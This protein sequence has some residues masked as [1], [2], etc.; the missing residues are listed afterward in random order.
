ML[1]LMLKIGSFT[2]NTSQRPSRL[3][4]TNDAHKFPGPMFK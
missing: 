3:L 2:E 4:L 1:S